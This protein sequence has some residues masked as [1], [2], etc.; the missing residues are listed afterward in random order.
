M[1]FL[2][3]YACRLFPIEETSLFRNVMQYEDNV[4]VTSSSDRTIRLWWKVF[5][6]NT[7]SPHEA[8]FSSYL[9]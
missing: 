6:S 8:L 4:L 3:F 7:E 2:F 5:S 1:L 9:R